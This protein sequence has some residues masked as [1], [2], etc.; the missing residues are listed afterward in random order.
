[1]RWDRVL[2]GCKEGLELAGGIR[3]VD[4]VSCGMVQYGRDGLSGRF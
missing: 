1:M 4:L 2:V 3:C